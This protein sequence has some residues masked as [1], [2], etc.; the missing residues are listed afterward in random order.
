MSALRQ[1]ASRPKTV[2]SNL[3]QEES[4]EQMNLD[5]CL[6]DCLNNGPFSDDLPPRCP[7]DFSSGVGG[8]P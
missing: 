8:C 4:D 5:C 7:L 3:H 2:V 1:K 6:L